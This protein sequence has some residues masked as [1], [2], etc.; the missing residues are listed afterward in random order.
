[1]LIS[2]RCCPKE[3]I[4]SQHCAMFWWGDSVKDMGF[5]GVLSKYVS[6]M[7]DPSIGGS[8]VTC[9]AGTIGHMV[10][11]LWKDLQ[12]GV[13][14][15]RCPHQHSREDFNHQ[16]AH[17]NQPMTVNLPDLMPY[18]DEYVMCRHD[19]FMEDLI[20]SLDGGKHTEFISKKLT[21]ADVPQLC[22]F[23]DRATISA[24]RSA[25]SSAAA[26]FAGRESQGCSLELP[27][28]QEKQAGFAQG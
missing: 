14:A 4:L 5:G 7:N 28:D 23:A 24:V 11:V 15:C 2:N 27:G 17:P 10:P 21:E 20:W 25:A 22:I 16:F 3:A 13:S 19:P 18:L 1:M 8:R 26:E 12:Q 9:I 6:R